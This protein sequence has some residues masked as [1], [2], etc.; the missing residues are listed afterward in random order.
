MKRLVGVLACLRYQYL[1]AAASNKV[2]VLLNTI[3]SVTIIDNFSFLLIVTFHLKLK[4]KFFT[5]C[6]DLCYT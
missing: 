1:K 3:I 2:S 5:H 6:E 4:L